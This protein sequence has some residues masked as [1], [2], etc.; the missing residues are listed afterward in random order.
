MNAAIRGGALQAKLSYLD[1]TP[2]LEP[3]TEKLFWNLRFLFYSL[4]G[5]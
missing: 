2:S 5:V 1:W 4:K 3:L